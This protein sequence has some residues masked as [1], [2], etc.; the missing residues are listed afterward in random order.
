[1]EILKELFDSGFTEYNF[2]VGLAPYKSDW[3]EH[4]RQACLVAAI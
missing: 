1:M 3:S 2:G 4:R